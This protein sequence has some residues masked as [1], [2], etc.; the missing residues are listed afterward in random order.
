M[1]EKEIVPVCIREMTDAQ[2]MEAQLIEL[3][4]VVKRFL[5]VHAGSHVAFM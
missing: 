2:V 3:S 1:A 5:F 4:R